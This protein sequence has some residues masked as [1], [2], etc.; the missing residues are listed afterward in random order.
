MVVARAATAQW[1]EADDRAEAL[2]AALASEAAA[3]ADRSARKRPRGRAHSKRSQKSTRHEIAEVIRDHRLAP[4]L[5]VDRNMVAALFF[6]HRDHVTN[7]VLVVAVA[8]ACSIITGRKL[9]AKKAERLRAASI[10]VK[11]LIARAE[12]IPAPVP[13][14]QLIPVQQPAESALQASDAL[15]VTD[16]TPRQEGFR[17]WPVAAALLLLIV[18]LLIMAIV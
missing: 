3:T 10:H 11:E 15:K 14:P 4:G 7:P 5:Q 12:A 2:V 18:T 6:G 17:W 9:S 16:V 13:A 1:Q 8:R